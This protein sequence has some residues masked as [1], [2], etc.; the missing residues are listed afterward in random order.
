MNAVRLLASS[1]ERRQERRRHA[2]EAPALERRHDRPDAGGITGLGVVALHGY[3]CRQ[4]VRSGA[5]RRVLA[6]WHAGD[7][8]IT[9]L[10]P[11][12][13][14]LLPSIRAFVDHLAAEFPKVVP[15]WIAAAAVDEERAGPQGTV[16]KL[17]TIKSCR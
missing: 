17:A 16:P 12:R 3:V 13:Q 10:I 1:C 6:N 15:P 8:M 2:A 7:S 5:L 4:E 9:A 11:Y 14:A